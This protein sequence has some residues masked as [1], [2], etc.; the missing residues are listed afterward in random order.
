MAE[1]FVRSVFPTIS[2]AKKKQNSKILI[3]ST[4]NGMNKF[5]QLWH[6][7][8]QGKGD[9]IPYK[10]DWKAVPRN[11]DND[12][13]YKQQIDV[14]GEQGFRQEYGCVAEDT[15][16]NL[17]NEETGEVITMSMKEVEEFLNK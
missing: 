11:T 8:E 7:A 17:K 15:M 13:F 14:I 6:K 16:I 12:T 5:Y 10:I 3:I 4:P 9:F 1:E 2:S